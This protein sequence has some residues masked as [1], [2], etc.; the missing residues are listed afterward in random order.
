MLKVLLLSIVLVAFVFIGFAIKILLEK[1]GKFPNIHIGGNKYLQE[2][3]VSC[4]T[5]QDKMERAKV[6]NARLYNQKTLLDKEL[7]SL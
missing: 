2:Q 1:N 6:R 4:A 3:G 7:E 5:S